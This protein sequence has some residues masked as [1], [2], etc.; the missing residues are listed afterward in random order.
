MT[1][2]KKMLVENSFSVAY[3]AP[4]TSEFLPHGFS[5]LFPVK[6]ILVQPF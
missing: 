3:L 5:V 6:D 4:F 2:S 1:L